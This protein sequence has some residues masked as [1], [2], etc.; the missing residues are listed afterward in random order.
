VIGASP[1][2]ISKRADNHSVWNE[3]KAPAFQEAINDFFAA[4]GLGWQLVNGEIITRGEDG[5]EAAVK[6]AKATLEE[7]GRPTASR[8]IHETLQALSRRPEPD[9]HGAVLHVMD[10][11]EC[12][13]RAVTGDPK[14]SLAKS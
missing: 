9:L 2:V 13:A 10:S 4:N 12:L 5:F 8:E 7:F 3:E 1:R 14:A 6:T 11:L